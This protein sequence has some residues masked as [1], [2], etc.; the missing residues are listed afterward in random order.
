MEFVIHTRQD[1]K[2]FNR[3]NFAH[4]SNITIVVDMTH[5]TYDATDINEYFS[6]F[7]CT[8]NTICT[9]N[10]NIKLVWKNQP[11]VFLPTVAYFFVHFKHIS[12][13]TY[14][15]IDTIVV[16]P[17]DTWF[18]YL[19]RIPSLKHLN[20]HVHPTSNP[21]ASLTSLLN[22]MMVQA[23]YS[24]SYFNQI[25]P[26]RLFHLKQ[27]TLHTPTFKTNNDESVQL[28]LLDTWKQQ[29]PVLGLIHLSCDTCDVKAMKTV[30]NSMSDMF[31]VVLAFV[32]KKL[33]FESKN[34]YKLPL[35]K[36]IQIFTT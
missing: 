22:M 30:A 4:A 17:I 13:L 24:K 9:N 5:L 21:D 16:S 14:L 12:S 28:Y 20:V 36:K 34:V 26:Y 19:L 15:H 3:A 2:K 31:D 35:S 7:L 29:S 32:D 1:L 27:L 8:I 23:T 11:V 18:F 6:F 10:C 33:V 25:W